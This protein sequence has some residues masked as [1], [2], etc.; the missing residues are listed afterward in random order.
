MTIVGE[1]EKMVK[2]YETEK[3][4]LPLSKSDV[5]VIS[6]MVGSLNDVEIAHLVACYTFDRQD[7]AGGI[8][9]GAFWECVIEETLR[10]LLSFGE[11][12]VEAIK[13]IECRYAG[14]DDKIKRRFRELLKSDISSQSSQSH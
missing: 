4:S 11:V 6:N 9:G 13:D 10:R 12:G 3:K 2:E 5:L 14:N 7:G 8:G 1:L